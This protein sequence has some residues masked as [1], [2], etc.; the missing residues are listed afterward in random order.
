MRVI[1]LIYRMAITVI[2]A[3]L[4][5]MTIT[6]NVYQ[7]LLLLSSRDSRKV[8]DSDRGSSGGIEFMRNFPAPKP[9][10]SGG[11]GSFRLALIWS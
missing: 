10:S 6:L 5:K 8:L 3:N 11:G 4:C 2:W 1:A 9:A 7:V